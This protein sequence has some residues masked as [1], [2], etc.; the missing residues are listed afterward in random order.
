MLAEKRDEQSTFFFFFLF[1]SREILPREQF[2]AREGYCASDAVLELVHRVKTNRADTTAMMFPLA[3]V[4]CI[5][6]FP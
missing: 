1:L 2:G 5:S 6:G 3:Q 4:L